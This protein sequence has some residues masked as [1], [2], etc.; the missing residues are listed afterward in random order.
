[1]F[2][3]RWY[4]RRFF[5]WRYSQFRYTLGTKMTSSFLSSWKTHEIGGISIQVLSSFLLSNISI[6]IIHPDQWKTLRLLVW[7][8]HLLCRLLSLPFLIGIAAQLVSY[9]GAPALGEDSSIKSGISSANCSS[10][11]A[12]HG[13][14]VGMASTNPKKNLQKLGPPGSWNKC[15]YTPEN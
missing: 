11:P 4:W 1:M 13:F 6:S 3:R 15:A 8:S 9:H 14:R 7:S 10:K 5:H 2:L 12:K